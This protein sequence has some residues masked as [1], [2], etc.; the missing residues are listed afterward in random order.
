[1]SN[2]PRS[3]L[4]SPTDNSDLTAAQAL[5]FPAVQPFVDLQR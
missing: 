4:N 3:P 2:D 1:M 5:N